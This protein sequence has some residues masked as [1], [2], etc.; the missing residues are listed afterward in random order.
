MVVDSSRPN[1]LCI[2]CGS[3][4]PQAKG[5]LWLNRSRYHLG[6][7]LGR[8]KEACITSG[9]H[10]RHVM[11]TTEPSTCCG[12]AA[13]LSNYT[14]TTCLFLITYRKHEVTVQRRTKN[15]DTTYHP[16]QSR[17]LNINI[18]E[19]KRLMGPELM[20]V[21]ATGCIHSSEIKIFKN[22]ITCRKRLIF[23]IVG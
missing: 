15:K 13:F 4:A 9:A 22:K 12:D 23:E 21:F 2:R 18:K 19:A 3:T 14:S 1:E 17:I 7:G 6:C 11:N 16:Q 5:Q 8:P 10:W 20:Q